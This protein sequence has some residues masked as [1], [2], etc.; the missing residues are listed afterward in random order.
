MFRSNFPASRR[1]VVYFGDT[2]R[3]GLIAPNATHAVGKRDWSGR[4]D[5]SVISVKRVCLGIDRMEFL[6]GV[7]SADV[8]VGDIDCR[9]GP[10]GHLFNISSAALDDNHAGL[11]AMAPGRNATRKLKK[12]R[13]GSSGRFLVA[14]CVAA[15]RSTGGF[16]V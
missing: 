4:I 6:F 12:K 9:I 16:A 3:K 1:V 13:P 2:N 8:C 15:Q 11:V 7:E 10:L 5:C 14:W